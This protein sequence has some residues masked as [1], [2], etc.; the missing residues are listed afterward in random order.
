MIKPT[1]LINHHIKGKKYETV[2]NTR[3]PAKKARQLLR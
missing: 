1:K 3:P 2:I